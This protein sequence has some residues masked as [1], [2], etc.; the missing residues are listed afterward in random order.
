MPEQLYDLEPREYSNLMR[1]YEL[2]REAKRYENADL[3]IMQMRSK[4]SKKHKTLDYILGNKER[5]QTKKSGRVVSLD[6]K[7]KELDYLTEILG[8]AVIR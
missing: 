6:E 8:E 4:D 2:K 1:G 7:R 3:V 5:K